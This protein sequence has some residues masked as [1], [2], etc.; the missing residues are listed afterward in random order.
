[1][2]PMSNEYESHE[3]PEEGHARLSISAQ[4]EV[5]DMRHATAHHFYE[6]ESIMSHSNDGSH[7]NPTTTS[8]DALHRRLH[9]QI[10]SSL[11]MVRAM[12]GVERF[13]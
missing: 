13:C 2:G 7:S 4:S 1:M 8:F 11:S 12:A 3:S 6:D 10:F 9:T 5:R